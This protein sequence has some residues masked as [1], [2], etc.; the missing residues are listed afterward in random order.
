[1]MQSIIVPWESYFNL[2]MNIGNPVSGEV[3]V[4]LFLYNLIIFD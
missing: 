2:F 4:D 3:N 1:M